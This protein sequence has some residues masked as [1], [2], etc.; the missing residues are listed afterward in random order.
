MDALRANFNDST[1]WNNLGRFV[2]GGQIIHVN[3]KDYDIKQCC[4]PNNSLP[5]DSL[6]TT[7]RSTPIVTVGGKQYTEM[8]CLVEGLIEHELG[9]LL[10]DTWRCPWGRASHT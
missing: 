7:M 9:A 2:A 8:M 6:G 1:A 10:G 3:G 4:Y 5:W